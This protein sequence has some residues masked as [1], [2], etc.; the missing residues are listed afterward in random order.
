MISIY[1]ENL[2]EV[3]NV[4]N[5]EWSLQ[6]LHKNI[7]TITVD[8]V[9]L[10]WLVKVYQ[11][12]NHKDLSSNESCNLRLLQG[13]GGIP[14]MLAEHSDNDCDFLIISRLPGLALTDYITKFG[15]FNEQGIKPIVISLLKILKQIHS[16]RIIHCDIKPDNII[17]DKT[18]QQVGI[19]DFEQ[20]HTVEYASPEQLK[21]RILSSKTDLWSLGI[22]IYVSLTGEFIFDNA[23]EVLGKNITLPTTWSED[24]QDFVSS[25]LERDETFRYDVDDALCHAW[26]TE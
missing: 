8:K 24:L 4:L 11:S 26:I 14:K 20:R 19:I 1:K 3:N 18:Y 6:R 13:V 10:N 9:E 21:C 12:P 22:T 15:T 16:R 7:F 2:N 23:R 5:M 17:Y 25:L